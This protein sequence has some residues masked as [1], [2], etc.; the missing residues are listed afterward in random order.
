MD[1]CRELVPDYLRFVRGV[2][3]SDSLSLNVSRELLQQDRQIRAIRSFVIRKVLDSLKAMLGTNRERYVTFWKEFGAILK[4]GL[5]GPE[6]PARKEALLQLVLSASS[7]TGDGLTTLAEY[8]ERMKPDQQAIYYLTGMARDAV[9]QSPHLEAFR[10]KGYEVLYLT[11]PVDELWTTAGLEYSGHPFRSVGKGA[12]DLGADG[13]KG[14]EAEP[15]A[16]GHHRVLLTGL[17]DLLKDDVKEVRLS[18]RLVASPACLVSEEKDMGPQLDE[19]MRRMG[20]KVEPK[21]RILEVNPKHELVIK[22]QRRFEENPQAPALQNYARLLYGQALLAEGSPLP[23]G[24]TY[25]RLIA[26][27]MSKAL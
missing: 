3:D 16:E 19:L 14:K 12:V 2:V 22:L 21:K 25:G 5:Y 4:Q 15:D 9:A 10:E 20:H 17:Q 6:E 13:E 24:A 26:E 8:V 27:L 7:Q 23:D 1:D 18:S 11:D